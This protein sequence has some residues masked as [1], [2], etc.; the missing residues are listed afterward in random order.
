MSEF[1]F[2]QQNLG[3]D[4]RGQ[5]LHTDGS[6][7]QHCIDSTSLLICSGL[8]EDRFQMGQDMFSFFDASFHPKQFH[9]IVATNPIQQNQGLCAEIRKHRTALH[10]F[11]P[12]TFER[13]Y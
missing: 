4:A 2:C 11:L 10:T 12:R 6:L 3:M 9:A 7:Q 1:V 8:S 13:N 5:Y